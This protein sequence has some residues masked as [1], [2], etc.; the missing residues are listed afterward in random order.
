MQLMHTNVYYYYHEGNCCPHFESMAHGGA[1]LDK[2]II[3]R[4]RN[5]IYIW[6]YTSKQ[7][8]ELIHLITIWWVFALYN[9]MFR[10]E[11][12]SIWQKICFS[13]IISSTETRR[14]INWVDFKGKQENWGRNWVS[15]K[16]DIKLL[17]LMLTLLIKSFAQLQNA[18]HLLEV[19][20]GMI[21]WIININNF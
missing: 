20:W 5:R 12:I 7:Q 4:H 3:F 21:L 13:Q 6:Q 14:L 2:L 16:R 18:S 8:H 1:K 15:G 10:N 9:N 17:W 11:W 19:T